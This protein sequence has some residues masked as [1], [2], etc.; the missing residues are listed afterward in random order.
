M[1][2]CALEQWD[3]SLA[4]HATDQTFPIKMLSFYLREKLWPHSNMPINKTTRN[5]RKNSFKQKY[6]CMIKNII[7]HTTQTDLWAHRTRLVCNP[8]LGAVYL[9]L[10]KSETT[11]LKLEIEFIYSKNIPFF[12]S[13]IYHFFS[14]EEDLAKFLFTYTSLYFSIPPS[15]TQVYA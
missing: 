15:D 13:K 11:F 1:D 2:V 5:M 6:P 14:N 9:L 7:Q 12:S 3:R 10:A 4:T 8:A